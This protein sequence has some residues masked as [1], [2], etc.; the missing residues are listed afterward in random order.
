MLEAW[1]AKAP[2]KK[3]KLE[4][5]LSD[6]EWHSQQEMA[7]VAEYRYGAALF[8][9]HKGKGQSGEPLHYLKDP[10]PEDGTRVRYRQT[11]E[12]FCDICTQERQTPS[13]V[14]ARLQARIVQLEAEV[15]QLRGQQ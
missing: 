5:L 8:E 3:A 4:A 11:L 6:G 12:A 14:I 7:A 10:H 1:R 13:Q 9:L 15:A 2:T